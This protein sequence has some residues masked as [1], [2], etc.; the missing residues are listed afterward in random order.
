MDQPTKPTG[1]NRCL[2]PR[3]VL[4]VRPSLLEWIHSGNKLDMRTCCSLCI[5]T[6]WKKEGKT[7][8]G[9]KEWKHVMMTFTIC[10]WPTQCHLCAKTV[11]SAMDSVLHRPWET[12]LIEYVGL[13]WW[14]SSIGDFDPHLTISEATFLM[15]T[16]GDVIGIQW[17]EI[18]NA[19]KYPTMHTAAPSFPTKNYLAPNAKSAQVEKWWSQGKE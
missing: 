5:E 3:I 4:L 18:R 1:H 12:P 8:E 6:E 11:L 14:F 2:W 7:K 17:V 16:T 9:S 13:N 15:V 19:D 10:L